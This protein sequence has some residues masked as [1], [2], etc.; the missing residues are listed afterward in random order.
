[1]GTEAS[2]LL[3]CSWMSIAS[4]RSTIAWDIVAEIGCCNTS[5]PGCA[6]ASVEATPLPAGWRR[7]RDHFAGRS[8]TDALH[9]VEKIESNLRSPILIGNHSLALEASTGVSLYPAHGQDWDTLIQRADIAMY[10]AKRARCGHLLFARGSQK[11]RSTA[12]R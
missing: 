2:R 4:R 6:R 1:M 11:I 9:V 8:A 12:W 7:V 3:S 5:V 10:Q